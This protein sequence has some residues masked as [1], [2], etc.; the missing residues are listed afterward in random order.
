MYVLTQKP[1][2]DNLA[3]QTIWN[4]QNKDP[5]FNDSPMIDPLQNDFLKGLLEKNYLR[6][7]GCSKETKEHLIKAHQWFADLKWDLL[8]KKNISTGY[9]PPI[10]DNYDKVATNE[11]LANGDELSQRVNSTRSKRKTR[12]SGWLSSKVSSM[13]SRN[14][15]KMNHSN[16]SSTSIENTS[17][18]AVEFEL[19]LI[20]QYF[21]PFDVEHKDNHPTVVLPSYYVKFAETKEIKS[22]DDAKRPQL[23]NK[24]TFTRN[25]TNAEKGP[26]P[27]A[28]CVPIDR[29]PTANLL[30]CATEVADT[31]R[32]R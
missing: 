28:A 29:E 23:P 18:S 1:F 32:G 10:Q 14:N 22:F 26:S 8:E 4:I 24:K 15:S 2:R 5:K 6:R 11:I 3:D 19:N 21:F 20:N 25:G 9:T 12:K 13:L 17:T 16:M 31:P 30:D 7:L 27:L